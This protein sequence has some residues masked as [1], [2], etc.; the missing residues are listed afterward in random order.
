MPQPYNY[1]TTQMDPFGSAMQGQQRGLMMNQVEQ[2][3]AQMQQAQ[4]QE[5]ALQNDL[6]DL[7]DNPSLQAY[8]KV[9]T[10]NPSLA[11]KFEGIMGRLSDEEKKAG[12]SEAGQVFT[13]LRNKRPDLAIKKL[14]SKLAANENAGRADEVKKIQTQIDMIKSFPDMQ[15]NSLGVMLGSQMGEDNFVKMFDKTLGYEDEQKKTQADTVGKEIANKALKAKNELEASQLP[16]DVK[17]NYAKYNKSQAEANVDLNKIYTIIGNVAGI[18]P[19]DFKTGAWGKLLAEGQVA[20]SGQ[21]WSEK[22]EKMALLHTQLSAITMS[23]AIKAKAAGAL[24]EGEMKELLK[25]VPPKGSTAPVYEKWLNARIKLVKAVTAREEIKKQY[26]LNNKSELP[27]TKKFTIDIG[28]KKIVVNKGEDANRI[29]AKLGTKVD[30]YAPDFFT[31]PKS[32]TK[33]TEEEVQDINSF[34]DDL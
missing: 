19:A 34:I 26:A 33:T 3:K 7:G 22:P 24:S 10:K 6:G 9:V 18:D 31:E 23:E 32:G 29:I 14:E 17:A 21:E 25:A 20:L 11:A 8:R 13:M 27:A 1:N 30:K 28:G 15:M 4:A 12:L 16:D 5:L 2:K